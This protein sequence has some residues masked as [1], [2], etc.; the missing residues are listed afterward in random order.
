MNQSLTKSNQAVVQNLSKS[1]FVLAMI[2][3]AACWGAGTVMSK[4]ILGYIPPLTLL[5]V[6]LIASLTF[7][8]TVIAVQRISIP[9]RRETLW[10]ALIGLL[11]PGLAYTFSLLGLSLTTASMSALLWAAEPIL[12]LGLA[13]LILRERLT[14]SL[15][16]CSLLAIIGVFLVIGVNAN[17][18]NRG[19]FGG[20]L[21]ILAGVLCC[22]LYTVLTRRDAATLNPV[23]LVALQ[24]TTALLWALLIWPLELGSG[25]MTHLTAISLSAWLWA[26]ASGIVYYA[27]AFWF[28]INGLKR[29]P[30]S[31]AGLFLNLIPIFAVGG[32]YAFLGE[33]LAA[34][35]WTGAA[36]IL[37]A[38]M[39]MLRFQN[40]E[41][42]PKAERLQSENVT[43]VG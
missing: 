33:R 28:Y 43:G 32:A 34:V 9:L 13:W 3:A 41:G 1:G 39:A 19:S 17:I 38:V 36:L 27:L 21:L 23:L 26:V 37:V 15:L 20:N 31:L 42:I 22:A 7:L 16:A 18:D 12:I 14:R 11:N 10:L 25:E 40:R 8:W 6:Q 35:Q 30:A 2:M 29:I 4:G 5:V 24:Q